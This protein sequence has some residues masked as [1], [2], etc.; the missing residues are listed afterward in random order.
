M[1][2]YTVSTTTELLSVLRSARS[3]DVVQL[4]SGTYSAATIRGLNLGNV[5]IESK[6]PDQPAVF[7]NLQIHDSSGL[8]FRDV[9][10]SLSLVA[11]NIYPVLVMRSNDVRFD[12]VHVHG[13]L[14]DNPGNDGITGLMVRES[15]NVTVTNS[16]FEQLK[17]GIAHL[18]S[19]GLNFSDNAFHDL[20]TDGIRGGGSSDVLI[21]YNSFRDF[22]PAPGDHPDGIQF[23][24]TNT[25]QAV[26]NIVVTGNEIV[27][28]DGAYVQG[29]FFRDEVTTLPYEN[30]TITNNIVIGGMYNGI[31]V[32]GG[33]NLTISGNTVVGLPDMNSWIR[34]QNVT[35]VWLE[36]NR[37]THYIHSVN[38]NRLYQS[39]NETIARATD[40]G[41]EALRLWRED[42][43][44]LQEA[45]AKSSKPSV[46]LSPQDAASPASDNPAGADGPGLSE[47]VFEERFSVV[48][49]L[50]RWISEDRA[51]VQMSGRDL[52]P[53]LGL[54]THIEALRLAVEGPSEELGVEAPALAPIFEG[55]LNPVVQDFGFDGSD[56]FGNPAPTIFATVALEIERE[57]VDLPVFVSPHHFPGHAEFIV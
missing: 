7:T 26:R 25:T 38:V 13:S 55:A 39:G 57:Q 24:T 46:F 3:G 50:A 17:W 31:M 51:P 45:P 11:G 33:L 36:D 27:R 34:L 42:F 14:D 41:L 40:G 37:S 12:N 32:D 9:D 15:R 18:D 47:P 56:V 21:A 49:D 30:V 35:N 43:S 52:T 48:T 54:R 29:I 1:A 23:W 6:Y 4:E 19:R 5:V 16:E 10:F 53:D 44:S 20:Q 2:T 22:Y 28:G 8:T